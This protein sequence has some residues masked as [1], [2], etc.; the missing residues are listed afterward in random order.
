MVAR[1]EPSADGRLQEIAGLL[2]TAIKDVRRLASE[3]RPVVLDQLGLPAAV[4]WLAGDFQRRTGIDCRVRSH[5]PDT[6][7]PA[8]VSTGLFRI[9]QEA[10]TNVARHSGA[11]RV[12]VTLQQASRIVYLE[13]TDNGK[14]LPEAAHAGQGSLGILGMRERALLLGGFIE[15]KGETGKGTKLT[16]WVPLK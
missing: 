6:T 1:R 12:E 10:L 5:L 8:D 16:A 4:E 2:D 15:L 7:L 14:G 3:L 9:L 13:V 11:S